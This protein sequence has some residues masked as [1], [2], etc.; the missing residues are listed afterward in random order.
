[1][2]STLREEFLRVEPKSRVEPKLRESTLREE[3][4]KSG[5]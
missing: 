3:F 1:M 5:A 2:E 4:F